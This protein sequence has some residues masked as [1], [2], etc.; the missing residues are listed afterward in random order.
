MLSV[1]LSLPIGETSCA[2]ASVAFSDA[3]R[4]RKRISIETRASAI[5]ARPFEDGSS[6][7][8]IGVFQTTALASLAVFTQESLS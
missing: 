3:V 4:P 7:A 2:G 5:E 8:S 6:L 1:I